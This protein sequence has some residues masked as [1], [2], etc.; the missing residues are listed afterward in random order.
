MEEE[1]EESEGV[2]ELKRVGWEGVIVKEV[3]G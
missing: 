3:G 1:E 2:R